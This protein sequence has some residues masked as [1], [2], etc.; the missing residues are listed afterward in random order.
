MLGEPV[1]GAGEH[2]LISGAVEEHKGYQTNQPFRYFRATN[3][4]DSWPLPGF[5]EE[6]PDT[7]SQM[8]IS[9][10][11]CFNLEP[12]QSLCIRSLVIRDPGLQPPSSDHQFFFF[13][14]REKH[15][16]DF[17]MPNHHTLERGKGDFL[18]PA[19]HIS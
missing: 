19:K 3:T 16:L 15:H 17:E 10:G 6:S 2:W 12:F 9:S 11:R 18:G 7:D 13:V 4:A 14:D 1:L 5:S 8:K